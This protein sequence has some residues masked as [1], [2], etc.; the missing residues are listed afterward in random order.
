MIGRKWLS[1]LDR[2]CHIAREKDKL[3]YFFRKDKMIFCDIFSIYNYKLL[4]RI[5][6]QHNFG[7]ITHYKNNVVHR[8][9]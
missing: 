7:R 1:Y 8:K 2:A 4:R 6:C 9:N 3:F 5:K